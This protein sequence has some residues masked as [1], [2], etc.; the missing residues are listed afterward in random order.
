V[1]K[2]EINDNLDV[3]LDDNLDVDNFVLKKT[4]NILV[5]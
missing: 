2:S 4:K 1:E 3:N 5:K